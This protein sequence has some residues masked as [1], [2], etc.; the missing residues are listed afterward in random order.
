ML[1][2]LRDA[3]RACSEAEA[4]STATYQ[5]RSATE[6][7]ADLA[8]HLVPLLSRLPKHRAAAIV[9]KIV[10]RFTVKR[11]RSLFGLMNAVTSVARDTRDPEVR[12]RLEELG[13][14][15]P[16]M[17]RPTPKPGAAA[18]DLLHV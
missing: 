11:D 6:R 10:D 7:E 16:S 1:A 5:M 15:I 8:L 12:W 17:V 14:G 18:A 4:F 2:G 13:G 3:V 9:S